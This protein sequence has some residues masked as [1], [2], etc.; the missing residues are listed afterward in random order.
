[1]VGHLKK[2]V[3]TI[4]KTKS[5]FVSNSFFCLCTHSKKVANF[6]ITPFFFSFEH[7]VTEPKHSF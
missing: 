3:T 4:S 2:K 7:S 5:I 1:M 6:C